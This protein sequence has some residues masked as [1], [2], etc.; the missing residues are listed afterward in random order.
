M[1]QL[2]KKQKKNVCVLSEIIDAVSWEDDS[3]NWKTGQK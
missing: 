1:N 3:K 2:P